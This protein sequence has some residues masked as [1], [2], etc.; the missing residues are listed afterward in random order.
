MPT[1]VF[2]SPL[3][4]IIM[5]SHET[6]NCSEPLSIPTVAGKMGEKIDEEKLDTAISNKSPTPL[7]VKA[8]RDEPEQELLYLKGA[9]LVCIVT[10]LCLS[11]LLVALVRVIR[12]FLGIC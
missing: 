3:L 11:V 2:V 4:D 9:K 10:G 8:L 1:D 12:T 7:E 6:E 5:S